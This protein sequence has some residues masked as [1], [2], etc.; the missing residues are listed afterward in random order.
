[1]VGG[2]NDLRFLVV[3]RGR[4]EPFERGVSDSKSPG[5]KTAD[6]DGAWTFMDFVATGGKGRG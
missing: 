3:H 4:K 5:V 6:Q 1:V 2:E